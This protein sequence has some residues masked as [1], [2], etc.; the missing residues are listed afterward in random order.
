MT[1][2][3]FEIG[4]TNYDNDIIQIKK[5]LSHLETHCGSP[6]TYVLSEPVS[7]FGWTFFQIAMKPILID[8]IENKFADMIQRYR[9]NK[10]EDKLVK[11]LS[12][13]FES[14][15]CKIRLKLVEY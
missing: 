4:T 9:D 12:D 2:A 13:F 7:K 8:G 1:M 6:N 11:F 14:R 15:G 5:S 10:P 3:I